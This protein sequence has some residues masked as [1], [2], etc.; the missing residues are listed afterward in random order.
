MTMPL[1]L[2][3]AAIAPLIDMADAVDCLEQA[4]KRW[5]DPGSSTWSGPARGRRTACSI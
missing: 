4:F 1:F 2:D 5:R 3:E